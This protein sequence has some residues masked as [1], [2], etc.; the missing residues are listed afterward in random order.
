[1][2]VANLQTFTFAERASAAPNTIP[3]LYS[4]YLE[5]SNGGISDPFENFIGP[6]KAMGYPVVRKTDLEAKAGNLIYFPM[7]GEL[8]GF[9]Q[10]GA[11]TLQGNEEDL[12]YGSDQVKIGFVRHAT[13]WTR[14]D[15]AF[16]S[17]GKAIPLAAAEALDSWLANKRTQY[18]LQRM[19]GR[20][21]AG[22]NVFYP[23]NKADI[24]ALG[25][26]DTMSTTVIERTAAFMGQ[27]LAKPLSSVRLKSGAVVPKYLFFGPNTVLQPLFSDS[28]FN[29]ATFYSDARDASNPIRYGGFA[30]WRGQAIFDWNAGDQDGNGP[31]GSFF[32]PKALLGTA[33]TAGTGALTLTGGGARYTSGKDYFR[34]FPGNTAAVQY[35]GESVS[36]SLFASGDSYFIKIYNHVA[37]AA[38]GDA[39]KWGFYR[40]LG[41]ANNNGATLT[42]ANYSATTGLGG[43][44]LAGAGAGGA[45]DTR[46][47]TVGTVVWDSAVNTTEHPVGAPMY[48]CNKA[49]KVIGFIGC[50]G[51]NAIR[52]AYG[53]TGKGNSIR[54]TGYKETEDYEMQVAAG[55]ECVMGVDVKTNT[56]GDP[57]NYILVPCVYTPPEIA[58]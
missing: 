51:S 31:I 50:L 9:G 15:L 1:M 10:V 39:T 32:N 27:I 16:S 14:E 12:P 54:G 43:G 2:P 36:E 19:R 58:A 30:Q 17:P 11:D 48:L 7:N 47:T 25:N 42:T 55:I 29:N 38:G 44:R 45:G 35:K 28:N 20:A 40:F 24:N 34:Y 23:N 37:S 41:S 46:F 56:Q 52:I 53:N 49:G 57:A 33:I 13:G 3:V 22:K 26:S 4:A 5:K 6:D 8:M 18:I 21:R